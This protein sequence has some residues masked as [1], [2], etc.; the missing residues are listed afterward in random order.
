MDKSIRISPESHAALK[1]LVPSMGTLKT[2]AARAIASLDGVYVVFA[3]LSETDI[4]EIYQ[5][6]DDAFTRA[7]E[8]EESGVEGYTVAS[9]HIL[10]FPDPLRPFGPRWKDATGWTP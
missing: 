3:E 9:R 6:E 5:H 8:L 7:R 4:V 1:K 2:V 10:D